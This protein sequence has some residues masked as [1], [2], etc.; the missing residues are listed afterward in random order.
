MI[1]KGSTRAIKTRLSVTSLFTFKYKQLL[2]SSLASCGA[3]KRGNRHRAK[4]TSAI[5]QGDV[6]RARYL[7]PGSLCTRWC[8]RWCRNMLVFEN[9]Q[10]F[11]GQP[12]SSLPGTMHPHPAS[13]NATREQVQHLFR[14]ELR[15]PHFTKPFS[16]GELFDNHLPLLK[17]SWEVQIVICQ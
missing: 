10:I 17:Y 14:S 6:N 3:K 11:G 1:P 8:Q 16:F 9:K 2:A 5:N 7:L 12:G 15:N 4:S 13:P